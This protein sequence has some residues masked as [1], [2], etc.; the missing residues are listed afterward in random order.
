[1]GSASPAPSTA[2]SPGSPCRRSRW[3]IAASVGVTR[4]TALPV[5]W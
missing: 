2:T 3:S 1:V 4:Q 5:T